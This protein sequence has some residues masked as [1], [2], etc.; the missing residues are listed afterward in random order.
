MNETKGV[1]LSFDERKQIEKLLENTYSCG[2]IARTLGRGK[3]TIVSEVRINGGADAYNAVEAQKS[4]RQRLF[5][6]HHKTFRR[7]FTEEEIDF[8]KKS[9]AQGMS[10]LSICE[11]LKCSKGT[12]EKKFFQ[13]SSD[14]LSLEDRISVL[15]DQIKII[16]SIIEEKNV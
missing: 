12:L 14:Y 7:E 9:Y 10:K 5:N 15:E 8:I 16:F 6:R 4:A 1:S 3:N 13:K 11:H 2:S